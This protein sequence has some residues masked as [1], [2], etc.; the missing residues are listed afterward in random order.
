M[1]LETEGVKMMKR[2]WCSVLALLA[3]L[4]VPIAAWGSVVYTVVDDTF[5]S[6]S[7]GRVPVTSGIPEV[8][9]KNVVTNLGG[10]HHVYGFRNEGN[11]LRVLLSQYARGQ[12]DTVWIYDALGEYR[13]PVKEARWPSSSN[14]R[15]V[16]AMGQ[17][18]YVVDYDNAKVSKIDMRDETYGEVDKFAFQRTAGY[19]AHGE[20]IVRV[21]DYLYALFSESKGDWFALEYNNGKIVK[22]DGDLNVVDTAD[23]GKNAVSLRAYN[24]MLYVVCLGGGQK[25][26]NFNP[27][28]M[29]QRV[30]PETLAVERLLKAGGASAAAVPDGWRYDFHDLAFAANGDVYVFA[31]AYD[32]AWMRFDSRIFKTTL[33]GLTAGN[34]GEVYRDPSGPG[35]TWRMEYD[36]VDDILWFAAGTRL[37]ACKGAQ[38]WEF[39]AAALG[40]NFYSFVVVDAPVNP[41]PGGSGGGCNSAGFPAFFLL[42][43]LPLL[44]VRAKGGR[45]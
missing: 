36:N 35:F 3:M 26:G 18:L 27:D 25:G 34:V 41:A 4:L 28:S 39:D 24:G 33:Q 8:P 44:C 12:S 16:A 9:V 11:S 20:R 37:M 31:G 6:G 1:Y 32:E 21:G 45:N 17:Y 29:I 5:A 22:L 23:V 19:E 14:I 43:L 13:A 15:G 7:M 30:H 42:A 10:D 2:R 38:T 40:G